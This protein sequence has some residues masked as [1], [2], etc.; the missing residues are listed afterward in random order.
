M[1]DVP[2][3]DQPRW[4]AYQPATYPACMNLTL[5]FERLDEPVTYDDP[6]RQYRFTGFK[7]SARLQASIDVPSL[8]FSWKSDPLERSHATFAVMG[9]EVNG[10]YYRPEA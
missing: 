2:V 8:G 3:V 7:A 6:V 4:P 1:R 10:R 9:D 5:L